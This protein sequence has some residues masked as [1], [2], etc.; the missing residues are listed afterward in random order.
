MLFFY[1][2]EG[3]NTAFIKLVSPG[4]DLVG[5]ADVIDRSYLLAG[6]LLTVLI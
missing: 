1:D 6:K 2:P 5:I 4:H 3:L